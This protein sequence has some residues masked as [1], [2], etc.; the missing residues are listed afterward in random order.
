M[1]ML[2]VPAGVR[3]VAEGE[4]AGDFYVLLAGEAAVERGGEPVR[5]LGPG[6][7]FGE[8]AFVA[9]T[10]RTATVTTTAPATI[11]AI[12]EEA[13]RGMLARDAGF[14]SRIWAAAEARL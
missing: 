11:L 6:D 3:V 5:T 10:R 9:R 14:R 12:D 1:Q 2:Q 8:I 4:R 13:F 7:F